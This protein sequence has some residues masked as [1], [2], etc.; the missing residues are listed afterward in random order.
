MNVKISI[1]LSENQLEFAE[2]KVREGAY[3]SVSE[4]IAESLRDTMLAEGENADQSDP[5]WEMRHEI[6]RRLQTPDDQWITMDEN[7]TMFE[8]LEARLRAKFGATA[9]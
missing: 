1:E 2:R 9:R 3:T 5:V 6:R 7:D 8:D 4:V